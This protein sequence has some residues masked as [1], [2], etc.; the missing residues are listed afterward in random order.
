[1]KII[2]SRMLGYS[3]LLFVLALSAGCATTG[4]VDAAKKM[5]EEAKQSADQANRTAQEAKDE[6]AAARAAATAAQQA[7]EQARTAAQMTNE[8][9]DRAFQ[10]SVQK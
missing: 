2:T 7:A 8:K 5:A 9:I 1:M 4:D 3:A 10:K 6:A